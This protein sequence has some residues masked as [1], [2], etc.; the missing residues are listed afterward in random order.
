MRLYSVA[1]CCLT[2]LLLFGELTQINSVRTYE[3]SHTCAST[4]AAL[5]GH[6]ELRRRLTSEHTHSPIKE[7]NHFEVISRSALRSTHKHFCHLPRSF[8]LGQNESYSK[9]ATLSAATTWAVVVDGG[10][11]HHKRRWPHTIL[12]SVRHRTLSI[13]NSHFMLS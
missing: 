6:C 3:S 7:P 11:A 5:Y 12:L 2:L 1:V 4:L 13:A 8:P 9:W 10:G